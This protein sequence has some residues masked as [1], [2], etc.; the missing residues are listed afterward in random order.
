MLSMM[1]R[2]LLSLCGTCGRLILSIIL[3]LLFGSRLVEWAVGR[4]GGW[5]GRRV[6]TAGPRLDALLLERRSD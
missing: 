3:M 5:L 2:I 1:R 4:S 6:P